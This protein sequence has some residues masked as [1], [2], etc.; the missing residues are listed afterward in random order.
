MPKFYVNNH[1]QTNGDHE[2]HKETC[3]WMPNPENRTYL[4]E[5]SSCQSAVAYSKKHH[6]TKSDGCAHC[7]P[8]AHTS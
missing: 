3:A 6:Y 7:C 8:E 4:G 5:F 1:A 2:V